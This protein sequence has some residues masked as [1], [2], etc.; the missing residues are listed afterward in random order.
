MFAKNRLL[1]GHAFT[2]IFLKNAFHLGFNNTKI[3]LIDKIVEKVKTK[4]Y[5][6]E[7]GKC[8]SSE[9][10]DILEKIGFQKYSLSKNHIH[11]NEFYRQYFYYSNEKKVRCTVSFK[12][13]PVKIIFRLNDENYEKMV[14]FYSNGEL[15]KNPCDVIQDK[16]REL[17]P[18]DF[19]CPIGMDIMIQPVMTEK[20]F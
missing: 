20:N 14:I 13:K 10:Y 2:P 18:K 17:I 4:Y 11:E 15:I 5:L 9:N 8:I 6:Y 16:F 19:I 12:K 1:N 7:E 3:F